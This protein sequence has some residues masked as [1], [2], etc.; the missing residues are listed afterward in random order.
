MLDSLVSSVDT[1]PVEIVDDAAVRRLQYR[2]CLRRECRM[3]GRKDDMLGNTFDRLQEVKDDDWS[4]GAVLADL[5]ECRSQQPRVTGL[6][7]ENPW[8]AGMIVVDA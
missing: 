3:L 4:A 2:F 6:G 7:R 1:P 8:Y 5:I